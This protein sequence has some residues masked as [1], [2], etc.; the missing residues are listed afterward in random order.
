MVYGHMN[1]VALSSRSRYLS[2]IDFLFYPLSRVSF[3]ECTFHVVTGFVACWKVR[4]MI[5]CLHGV[6]VAK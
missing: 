2:L 3:S 4:V 6:V 1:N 5:G